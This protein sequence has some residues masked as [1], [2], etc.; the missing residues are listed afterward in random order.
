MPKIY[1]LIKSLNMSE[2]TYFRKYAK[3]HAA[4]EQIYLTVFNEILKMD[5]YDEQKL[6]KKMKVKSYHVNKSGYCC[7]VVIF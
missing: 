3:R 6:I 1:V 5:T 2:I 4:N 7:V